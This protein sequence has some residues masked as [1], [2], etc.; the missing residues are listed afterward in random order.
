MA[1]NVWILHDEIDESPKVDLRDDLPRVDHHSGGQT[2]P[3][4]DSEN[5]AGGKSIFDPHLELGMP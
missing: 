3:T 4:P 1:K 2:V 5:P